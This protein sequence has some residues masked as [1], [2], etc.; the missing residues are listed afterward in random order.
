VFVPDAMAAV[1]QLCAREEAYG[2]RWVVPG[3]GVVT[4]DDIRSIVEEC[5]G[6][7]IRVRPAGRWMLRLAALFSSDLRQFMPMVPYYLEEVRFDGSRLG[8]LIGEV[9]ATPYAQGIRMTLDWITR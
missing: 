1:A 6:R 2:K 9:Q 5:L 4:L 8:G 3:A 7:R